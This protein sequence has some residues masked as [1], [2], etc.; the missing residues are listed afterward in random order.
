MCGAWGKT[1]GPGLGLIA[2]GLP[3]PGTLR[4]DASN[5]TT[6]VFING[7]QLHL[8]DALGLQMYTGDHSFK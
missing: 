6:G 5:G 1:G 4:A 3:L 8:M 7:R 2:P